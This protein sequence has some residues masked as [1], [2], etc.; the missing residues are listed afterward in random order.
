MGGGGGGGGGGKTI[1]PYLVIIRNK[2][3]LYSKEK[4][5]NL[6]GLI[7]NYVCLIEK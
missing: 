4:L 2:K 3:L 7:V 1:S 6:V 5:D